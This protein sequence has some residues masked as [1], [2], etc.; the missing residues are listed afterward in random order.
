MNALYFFYDPDE[1]QARFFASEAERDAYAALAL[2][3][4]RKEADANADWSDAVF[5]VVCGECVVTHIATPVNQ[6]MIPRPPD[7]EI[8]EDGYDDEGN[9][10][11]DQQR[12]I[13][14]F[15]VAMLPVAQGQEAP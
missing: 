9:S 12:E 3:A 7:A 15:D 2:A 5:R 6:E 10:W 8:D 13:I 11:N 14:T 4:Y 1:G